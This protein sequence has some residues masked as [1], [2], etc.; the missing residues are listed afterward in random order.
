[1]FA[2]SVQNAATDV[3]LTVEGLHEAKVSLVG[4]EIDS[5]FHLVLLEL[6]ASAG[7]F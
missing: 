1:M 6:S 2:F 7:D 3:K 5:I 4:V